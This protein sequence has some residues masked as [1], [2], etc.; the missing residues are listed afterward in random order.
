L[1]VLIEGHLVGA[2]PPPPPALP[3]TGLVD[4]DAVDPG[5]EGGLGAEAGECPEDAQEDFLGQVHRL[6][7]VTQQVQR[8]REYHALVGA[9]QF[10]TGGIV[11]SRAA[12]DEGGFLTVD[13][14]P[15]DRTSVLHQISGNPCMHWSLA[16]P[17]RFRPRGAANVPQSQV[18]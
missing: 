3:V 15:A 8:Q 16:P 2:V 12:R 7:A 4:D 6:V 13:L 5:A 14:R 1:Q 11:A 17:G 18:P 10:R 9:D